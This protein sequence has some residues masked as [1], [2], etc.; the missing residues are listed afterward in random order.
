MFSR[1]FAVSF[2]MVRDLEHIVA[3]TLKV[4]PLGSWS[5][6]KVIMALDKVRGLIPNR[7]PVGAPLSHDSAYE[8]AIISHEY[9]VLEV[10]SF[11]L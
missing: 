5:P 7:R 8:F 3:Q 10:C 1:N 11:T 2:E 6:S 9:L 4:D